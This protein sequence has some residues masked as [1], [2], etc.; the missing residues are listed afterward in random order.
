MTDIGRDPAIDEAKEE[1]GRRPQKI[2]P[3]S[4]E[5]AAVGARVSY[6]QQGGHHVHDPASSRANAT[7]AGLAKT[8]MGQQQRFWPS[9]PT[10]RLPSIAAALLRCREAPLRAQAV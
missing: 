6:L 3:D 8:T 2:T 5:A 9:P 1:V 7:L 4:A 10:V